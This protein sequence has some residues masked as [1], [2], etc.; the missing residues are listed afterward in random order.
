MK[1]RKY[2]KQVERLDEN[3]NNHYHEITHPKYC[4]IYEINKNILD[5]DL[6]LEIIYKT[7]IL[8]S[9]GTCW[10]IFVNLFRFGRFVAIEPN[11]NI[12]LIELFILSFLVV[13][14]ITDYILIYKRQHEV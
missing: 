9:I 13:K 12:A 6:I 11:V 3:K 7:G 2:R 1:Q 10:W 5:W 4:E 8:V 14:A